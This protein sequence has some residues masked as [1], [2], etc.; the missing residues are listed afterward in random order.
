MKKKF[1]SHLILSIFLIAAGAAIGYWIISSWIFHNFSL[2]YIYYIPLF[3]VAVVLPLYGGI[4]VIIEDIKT[5][6][7]KEESSANAEEN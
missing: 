7:S 3:L 1:L 4:G 6:K 5:L 2:A